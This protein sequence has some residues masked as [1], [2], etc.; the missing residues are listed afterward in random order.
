[1]SQHCKSRYRQGPLA[2]AYLAY[3][4][5]SLTDRS[6]RGAAIAGGYHDGLELV[7]SARYRLCPPRRGLNLL[8][9]LQEG[10]RFPTQYRNKSFYYLGE[11]ARQRHF[12]AQRIL[13][14]FDARGGRLAERAHAEAQRI[15]L[16]GCP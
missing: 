2:G 11:K 5:R 6:G 7:V 15:A 12:D 4:C 10:C 9:F 1:M 8:L 16:L 3:A 14:D 13:E